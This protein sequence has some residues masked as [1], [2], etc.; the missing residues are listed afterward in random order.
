MILLQKPEV[1]QKSGANVLLF[2][3]GISAKPILA[4][5]PAERNAANFFYPPEI[6]LSGN[7]C[8]KK[9]NRL[10][11]GL[12]DKKCAVSGVT[13]RL[14]F[15][16]HELIQ[17]CTLIKSLFFFVERRFLISINAKSGKFAQKN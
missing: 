10:F 7:P 17:L 12:N 5:A 16:G 4:T 8:R 1:G 15:A 9:L 6:S 13:N 11:Y 3:F 14:F 2:L